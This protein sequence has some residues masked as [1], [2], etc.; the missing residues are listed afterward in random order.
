MPNPTELTV[1]QKSRV[2]DIAYDDGSAYSIPLAY[3]TAGFTVNRDV[4]K[5]P[6]D[7]WSVFFEPPA[8]LQGKL[9]SLS[10][11]DEVV[12]GAQLFLGVPFCSDDRDE[13]KRV[14]DLLQAHLGRLVEAVGTS[15]LLS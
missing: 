14:L 12:G 15:D 5:G 4:Y 9:A 2:L 6:V 10:Y 1:H 3:G 13:M 11:P 7:S 8:E